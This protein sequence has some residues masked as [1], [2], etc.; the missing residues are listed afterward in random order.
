MPALKVAVLGAWHVH[1]GDYAR[2]TQNHPDTELIAVWDTNPVLGKEL[3]DTFGVP[4]TDDL[5][6]LLAQPDLDAV[7]ITTETSRHPEVIGAALRAGKHVFTEKLLAATVADAESLLQQANDA[8]V[9]MI[10]SLPRLYHGYTQSVLEHIAS[11]A[12]GEL[13]YARVRL[14]HDGATTGWLPDR[15]FDPEPAIGGALTDLGCHPVYLTQLF[16]GAQPDTVSATY[17]SLTNKQVDDHAVVTV[18]YPDQRIGVIEAGF[19]SRNPFTIDILG[20]AGELHYSS[21]TGLVVNGEA[22]P[23]ADDLPDAYSQWVDHI[24]TGSRATE[25]LAR[26]LELTRLVVAANSSA[27]DGRAI[28]YSGIDFSG[29]IQ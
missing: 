2:S 19:V 17:R 10:V 13:T 9:S 29:A 22:Q 11:G 26:A 28:N 15:F 5:D 16:L 6:A 12:L 7:T 1:A 23:V 20:V 14:S 21:D 8:G 3:A 18:G 24:R 4:Y 25:N 27:A